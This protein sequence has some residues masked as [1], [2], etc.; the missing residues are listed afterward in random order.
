MKNKKSFD[1][2]YDGYY[3][4][5]DSSHESSRLAI[6]WLELLSQKWPE[7]KADV[8]N[9]DKDLSN[10]VYLAATDLGTWDTATWNMF[11][12]SRVKA[13]SHVAG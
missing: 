6:D 3:P 8:I 2:C 12:W 1:S 10:F 4:S 5:Y 11:T 9:Y 13:P 7:F